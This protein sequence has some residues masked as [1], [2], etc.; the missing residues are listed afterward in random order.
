VFSTFDIFDTVLVRLVGLPSDVFLLVA[1]RAKVLGVL[2]ISEA[3]FQNLRVNS[4]EAARESF[5]SCEITID[6]IYEEVGYRLGLPVDL[7]R[8]K[9]I[10]MEV[11]TSLWRVVPKAVGLISERR[12]RGDRIGFISDMYLPK[13]LIAK[14]L[15]AANVLLDADL[16]WVSSSEGVTKRT[17]ALFKLIRAQVGVDW[18]NWRHFGDNSVSDYDVPT[19]LG[20]KA[21]HFRDSVLT[22][23][24]WSLRELEQQDE[25][26]LSCLVGASRL[27]RLTEPTQG[28]ELAAQSRIA[29]EFAAPILYS[30]VR[31]ILQ[32]AINQGIK[33]VWFVARDGQIMMKIARQL[34]SNFQLNLEIGYLYATRQLLHL[35]SLEVVDDRALDWITGGA[36]VLPIDAVLQRVG[37][38]VEDVR[39]ELVRY[40]LPTEKSLSWANMPILRSFFGD[41]L[42]ASKI[43]SRAAQSR[44]DLIR[45][46]QDCNL[47]GLE[48]FVIADVGWRG[49]VLLSLSKLIGMSAARQHTYLYF[50]LYSRPTELQSF[51][52]KGF[53]FD[54]STQKNLGMNKSLEWLTLFMEIFCQADHGPV[55]AVSKTNGAFV[56]VIG[57]TAEK[58]PSWNIALFHERIVAFCGAASVPDSIQLPFDSRPLC[59]MLL[60]KLILTPSFEDARLMGKISFSDDQAGALSQPIAEPYRVTHLLSA[61]KSGSYPKVYFNWWTPGALRQ[62]GSFMRVSLKLLIYV[63]KQLRFTT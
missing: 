13:A 58:M 3:A 52:M 8:L 56:P 30:Y 41:P 38:T 50:G 45:Y 18:V 19:R 53:L 29:R 26:P 48:K 59:S 46:Y 61:F 17:G 51:N 24:E 9:N 10:E 7:E 60:R 20:I 57:P 5:G 23:H 2:D 33:K 36:G 35:A 15:K 49:N 21:E 11:E 6:D 42:V 44:A 22:Q 16:L 54:S 12:Q 55:L 28:S 1:R 47:A 31:W 14:F 63:R 37:L 27:L 62:T 40:G 39:G 4:E 32:E 43:Q 25:L 34:I